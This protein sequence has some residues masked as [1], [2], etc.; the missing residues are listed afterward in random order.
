MLAEDQERDEGLMV[1]VVGAGLHVCQRSIRR[2][3]IRL[4]VIPSPRLGGMKRCGRSRSGVN[5]RNDHAR[6]EGS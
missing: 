4:P 3:V 1:G 5:Q 2:A 6:G